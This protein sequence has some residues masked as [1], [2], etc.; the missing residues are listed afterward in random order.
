[1][2]SRPRVLLTLPDRPWP[3][4]G[5]KR[6]RSSATLRALAALDVD[7]DVVVLAGP[8]SDDLLPPDVVVRRCIQVDAPPRGKAV[9]AVVAL[10]RAVPWQIAAVRWGVVR[11]RLASVRQE[12]YDL[13]WFGATDHAVSLGPFINAARRVVDM[14]DVEV[15][16]WRAFLDLPPDQPGTRGPVRIQRRVELPL[17]ARLQRRVA[18]ESDAVVVCSAQDRSALADQSNVAVVPNGYP[19]PDVAAHPRH[20]GSATIL[21]VGS[22]SYAPNVD[23]ATYAA[24]HVLP[25]VRERIPDARLR[26]VGR[27]GFTQLAALEG[28]PGVEI[29]G[30]VSGIG[31]ELARGDVSLVPIRFGGGTRVKILEAFAYRIP[32][33]STPLGC[34]GL[35]VAANAQL[36]VADDASGLAEACARVI[37]DDTLATRL[38]SSA[39]DLYSTYYRDV[40][41]IR[42]A[43]SVAVRLLGTG[44]SA[45]TGTS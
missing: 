23:A 12:T 45:V 34:E 32:V 40:D 44:D 24:L 30:E 43:Q 28:V 13:V 5:G 1:V 38:T 14:D 26:L 29:V 18:R 11:R 27:D 20:P 9:A 16:K 35:S 25:R 33:V 17:W 21:Y 2:T 37:E 36:L 41:A 4:N 8:A 6:L 42:E 39:Y 15:T 3:I 22:F 31:Q 10:A 19:D 7:L